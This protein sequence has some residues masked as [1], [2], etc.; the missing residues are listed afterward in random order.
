M[1]AFYE[2]VLERVGLG[3]EDIAKMSIYK[4]SCR[5]KCGSYFCPYLKSVTVIASSPDNAEWRV[6]EWLNKEDK[7]F[8]Y[9]E[10]EWVTVFISNIIPGVID[11]DIDSDY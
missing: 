5:S 4:V 8:I 9:A 1:K 2:E 7:N 11:C 6:K 10:T 3:T